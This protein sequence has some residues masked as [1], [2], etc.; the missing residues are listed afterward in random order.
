MAAAG[1]T[2]RALTTAPVP[3]EIVV[4]PELTSASAFPQRLTMTSSRRS[5]SLAGLM[6]PQLL[7][8]KVVEFEVA[9]KSNV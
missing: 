1:T 8:V 4:V 3:A 2:K 7:K 5:S 6:C 9:T